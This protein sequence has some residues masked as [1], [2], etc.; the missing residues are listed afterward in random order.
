MFIT[1]YFRNRNSIQI[2]NFFYKL[3]IERKFRL[4]H[5][6]RINI[7]DF[8]IVKKT[9]NRLKRKKGQVR[10]KKEILIN[11]INVMVI[12]IPRQV[13]CQDTSLV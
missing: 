1:N 13:S 10:V 4:T 2:R 7:E 5:I 12:T 11:Y 8:I 6:K 3:N 9:Y